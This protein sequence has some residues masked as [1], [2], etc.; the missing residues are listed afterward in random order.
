M[1]SG[2][3][4]LPPQ[5]PIPCSPP[6]PSPLCFVFCGDDRGKALLLWVCID[7]GPAEGVARPAH[8]GGP[9]AEA[10]DSC[11][12]PPPHLTPAKHTLPSSISPP[13]T[14][15][16]LKTR[17]PFLVRE[18]KRRSAVAFIY[19]HATS[20]RP[21]NTESLAPRT[22]RKWEWMKTRRLSTSRGETHSPGAATL[23]R[24]RSHV[25]APHMKR[26]THTHKHTLCPNTIPS[27]RA[28]LL[29]WPEL[30]QKSLIWER[31]HPQFQQA[32]I[33]MLRADS[34]F[35]DKMGWGCRF[36]NHP[37]GWRYGMEGGG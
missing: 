35:K 25:A 3:A 4:P 13:S 8:A 24:I 23:T 18:V 37:W 1:A 33:R 32:G 16:L 20:T 14:A 10:A 31:D 15:S 34:E 6:F 12:Q 11:L 17:S 36:W 30:H 19:L 5:H 21:N 22:E 2:T 28:E 9:F 27:C 26:H 29:S 7:R